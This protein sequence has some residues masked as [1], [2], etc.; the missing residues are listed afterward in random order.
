MHARGLDEFLLPAEAHLQGEDDAAHAPLE[1]ASAPGIT[2]GLSAGRA[3][4]LLRQVASHMAADAA[5]KQAVA[6]AVVAQAAAQTGRARSGG[7][8]ADE[9]D[10][11]PGPPPVLPERELSERSQVWLSVWMLSPR[12]A[13]AHG[14]EHDEML[15][16]GLQEALAAADS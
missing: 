3:A 16:A 14:E 4:R 9:V 7:L 2:T 13:G 10:E 6:R 15:L 11:A 8:A 1:D 5:D 12:L